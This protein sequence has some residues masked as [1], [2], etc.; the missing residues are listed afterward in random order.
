M[1]IKVLEEK[2]IFVEA[3]FLKSLKLFWKFCF[4]VNFVVF[5]SCDNS[6]ELYNLYK[7]KLY[8]GRRWSVT[9]ILNCIKRF[10]R[11]ILEQNH[12]LKNNRIKLF[13]Y[14]Y[15]NKIYPN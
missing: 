6:C 5:Y 11:K 7:F 3:D 2:S 4:F 9:L 8:D 13:S 15:K 12:K 1:S 14:I 10:M